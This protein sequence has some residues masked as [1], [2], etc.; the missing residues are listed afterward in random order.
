MGLRSSFTWL[1]SGNVLYSACQWGIVW[2]IA[3][4]GSTQQVGEY[5]LGMAIS[6]P[7][8]LFGNFQLR[9]L[10]AS[11]LKE[12]FALGQ[13]LSFRF[14]SL[15]LGMLLIAILA[16]ATQADQGVARVILLVGLAQA[17]DFVSETFYGVMQREERLDRLS[18]SLLMKGPI[19]LGALVAVM[20]LTHNLLYALAGLVAGRLTILLL[21]DSRLEFARRRL[22]AHLAWQ[23][24][25]ALQLFRL[26]LPLGIVSML[27]SV[28]A[29]IPRYFLEAWGGSS[30]LGIFSA[31]ASLLSAGTLIVSAM[32]Q[33]L[34]VPV[35]QACAA[36]DVA[37]YRT[38]LLQAVA[39]AAALGISAISIALLFG[40][41]IL[42]TVFGPA[43]SSQSW[44]LV[45]LM[46]AGAISFI[47]SSLG[48]IMTAARS[49][50]PQVVLMALSAAVAAAASAWFIP[51]YGSYGAAAA[52]AAS[53]L[54]QLCGTIVILARIDRN[55]QS[56][57]RV[58]VPLACGAEAAQ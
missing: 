31:I 20:Y 8:M 10:I 36:G 5:A 47:A 30:A 44:L 32:G 12:T 1:L 22:R 3:R 53:A 21:W 24:R 57:A 49:F 16:F 51:R 28:N 41:R 14:V 25:K 52:I 15:G 58:S 50:N 38:F 37:G 42:L 54:V 4:L 27:V 18:R 11:D 2:A 55:I 7:I 29:N 34:F 35:A 13:Y 9:A 45:L 6:A 43:Y 40:Q 23:S 26:A 19:A 46:I 56:R 33:S 17:M 39:L 48:Y